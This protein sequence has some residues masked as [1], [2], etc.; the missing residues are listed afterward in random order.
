LETVMQDHREEFCK[1]RFKTCELCAKTIVKCK[2]VEHGKECSDTVVP[3]EWA[4]YGCRH[5]DMRKNQHLHECGFQM[6]G[7]M[8]EMLKKEISGLR[9]DV[10]KLT[11]KNELQERR[12]KFLENGLKD[13]DKS[14]VP[15]DVQGHSVSP[16]AESLDSPHEYLLSLVEAQEGRV[17]QLVLGLTELDA[18][19]TQTDLV[20]NETLPLKDQINELR[21]NQGI[22]GMHVRWLMNFRRRENQARGGSNVNGGDDSGSP[23]GGRGSMPR[24][25]SDS[26]REIT[27]KL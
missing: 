1:D 7:T 27:M 23:S 13:V 22:L 15:S 6:V 10:K 12:I 3:C 20:L 17:S 18:R 19:Q 24:R 11:E 9:G 14:F 21:S 26:T 5:E 8:A 4:G 2:E 16:P 25:S